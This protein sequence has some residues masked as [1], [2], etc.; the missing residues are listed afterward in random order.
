MNLIAFLQSNPSEIFEVFMSKAA[1]RNL[2][3]LFKRDAFLWVKGNC[4]VA[5]TSHVD[6]VDFDHCT[7]KSIVEQN[8][9]ITAYRDGR[10]TI[11]GGDD[12]VGVQICF[13][14]LSRTTTIPHI[15]LFDGEDNGGI[16]SNLFVQEHGDLSMIDI[17][18]S[19]DACF[20]NEF[21]WYGSNRSADGWVESFGW[22]NRGKG[23][24]TDISTISKHYDFPCVNL[25]V[26]YFNQ[27]TAL[28]YIDVEVMALAKRKLNRMLDATG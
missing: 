17:M 15:F 2:E 18:I 22:K 8:G 26:G 27:H 12:R 24:F 14:S 19:L 9:I 4:G 28:E 20:N 5:L 21:V 1:S 6:T 3:C 13:E 10:R 16:C 7:P 23:I 11:L 25:G